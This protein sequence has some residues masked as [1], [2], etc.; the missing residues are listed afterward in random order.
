MIQRPANQ[1]SVI[2]LVMSEQFNENKLETIPNSVLD[3]LSQKHQEL[4]DDYKTPDGKHSNSC[5]LI[6]GEV[7][8]LL[9]KD[10]KRPSIM[11]IIKRNDALVPVQYGGRVKWGGHTVCVAEG[12]VFDPMVGRPVPL[13]EYPMVA[14]G[15]EVEMNTH[16]SEDKIEEYLSK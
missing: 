10:G 6:A 11:T 7:A 3:F 15:T 14:F 13:S 2:M 16:V 1:F 9:L 4:L 8:E 12:L 5:S